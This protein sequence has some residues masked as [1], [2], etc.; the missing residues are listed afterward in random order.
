MCSGWLRSSGGL[1]RELSGFE[2][3]REVV[4][5]NWVCFAYCQFKNP[6]SLKQILASKITIQ[7][8]LLNVYRC[9]NVKS[10]S[11]LVRNQTFLE[12]NSV[13]INNRI[14][15]LKDSEHC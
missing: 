8:N 5:E 4:E 1:I 14:I 13:V 3:K 15:D 11:Y 10:N 2:F 7:H 6:M 12:N 9:L